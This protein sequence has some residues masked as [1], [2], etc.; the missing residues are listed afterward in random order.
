MEKNVSEI[1]DM[2]AEMDLNNLYTEEIVTDRKMGT[3]RV[4][5]PITAQGAK[6]PTRS[7]VFTGEVQVMTQMGPLPINF[8]I[9]AR[10]VEEAVKNYGQAAKDGVKQTIERLKEMRRE[11]ANKIVTPGTPGFGVPQQPGAGKIQ[12]P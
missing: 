9:P 7:M 4:L 8:E 2:N 10:T 6:D 12:M 5:T 11:A 3:I 1:D